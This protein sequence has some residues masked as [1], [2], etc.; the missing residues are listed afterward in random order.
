MMKPSSVA[1]LALAGLLLGILPGCK[2]LGIRFQSPVAVV[3]EEARLGPGGLTAAELQSEVMSFTDTFNASIS[4]VWNQVAAEGRA[5]STPKGL[6]DPAAEA[7]RASQLRR[8][9]LENK[10]ATVNA[11]LSIAASP[12]PTVALGDM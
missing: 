8:A 7:E 1:F 9:S 12:N 3:H 2:A 11:A 4:Q 6:A 10:L 5:L